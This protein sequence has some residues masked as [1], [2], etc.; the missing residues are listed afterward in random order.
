MWAACLLLRNL[1]IEIENK[2]AY[3]PKL[4]QVNA[5]YGAYL[6]FNYTRA[7][8]KNTGEK[9]MIKFRPFNYSDEDYAA[10]VNVWNAVWTDQPASMEYEQ[11]V[12]RDR[13]PQYLFERLLAVS[14]PQETVVGYANFGHRPW[15][16]HPQKFF[17]DIYVSPTD[18]GRGIGS[19]LY[20][21]FLMEIEAQHPIM[22]ESGTRED[23]IQA[24]RFLEK[25]GF[26]VA[27]RLPTSQLNAAEFDKTP[28]LPFLEK[29]QASGLQIKSFRE[30][31][32][33][34]ADHLPQ[35]Y[36]LHNEVEQ[37]VPW[38]E[39]IKQ[40]PFEQWKKGY[41]N[42]PDLLEDGYFVALDGEKYVGVSYL[43][44]SQATDEILYTGFTGVRRAYRLRGI[45]TALKVLAIEYAQSHPTKSGRPVRIRTNN[46]ESNPMFQIN[47][48]LGF[49][50]LPAWLAYVKHLDGGQTTST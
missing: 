29:V 16:Y 50:E 27:T 49:K 40:F 36:D 47:L 11:R 37:D 24:M 2:I 19:Y 20:D 42:N 5:R 4:R 32:A 1:L 3:Y 14:F 34:R 35:L 31:S 30:L 39:E 23:K 17:I 7:F 28:F 12:D 41:E 46:E 43:W 15:S 9:Y 48:M 6:K 8:I 18:Q 21:Q 33:S 38:H 25:R 13:N 22:L 44:S 45:A 26:Q 10:M